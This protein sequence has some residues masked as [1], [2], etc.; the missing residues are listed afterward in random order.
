MKKLFFLYSLF[1]NFNTHATELS[2]HYCS[3]LNLSML[4]S[5]FTRYDQY[6]K[7]QGSRYEMV[8]LGKSLPLLS[9]I[10]SQSKSITQE[11]SYVWI[12]LQ[13]MGVNEAS[14]LP[15]FLLRCDSNQT[16]PSNINLD[17]NLQKNKTHFGID[18]LSIHVTLNASD[19]KCGIN[20]TGVSL[21]VNINGNK[22]EIDQVKAE[23]LKPAGALS[24]MIANLFNEDDFFKNYFQNFYAEL[25]KD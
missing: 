9:M 23:V 5:K 20:Q 25:S 22:A 4:F 24:G 15:R 6:S 11:S 3:H 14:L 8:L 19:E 12:V 18:D 13:P 1:F 16:Q 17:C 7:F 10:K 2:V 21:Q